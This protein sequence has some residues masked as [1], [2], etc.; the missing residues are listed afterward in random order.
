MPLDGMAVNIIT[1]Q[2]LGLN[3]GIVVYGSMC[4]GYVPGSGVR[5]PGLKQGTTY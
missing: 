3:V 1:R 5:L 4:S 2:N